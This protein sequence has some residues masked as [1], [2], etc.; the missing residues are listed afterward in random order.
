M[1]YVLYGAFGM[2][3]VLLLLAVGALIGWRSHRA[4]TEHTRRAV[5]KE[6]T[7][8]ERRIAVEEQR[9]FE[10]ML[11]YNPE[12]AYGLNKSLEELARGDD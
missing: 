4:W 10:S 11:N 5:A 1:T 2:L 9:A 3:A 6:A 8:E 12:Q 7:E